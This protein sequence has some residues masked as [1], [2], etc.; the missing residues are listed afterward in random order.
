MIIE[1]P[2]T[3]T[4]LKSLFNQLIEQPIQTK[5][6][7]TQWLKKISDLESSVSEDLAWRYIRMT[8][9]T[10]NKEHEVA[11]LDFVQ[12]IQPELAPLED[13]L[14]RKVVA[15]PFAKEAEQDEAVR[16][17]FRSLRG[18]IEL[19]REE[20]I[21]LQAELSTLAQEYSSIQGAMSVNIDGQTYTMQQAS[22]FLLRTDRELREKVWKAM[23]E[24][25]M[26]DTQKLEDLFDAMVA[27]RQEVAQNAGFANF[28]DYMFKALGR[29]DYNAEDCKR[30]HDAIAGKVVPML[31]KLAQKRKQ[32]LAL[33]TLK[34][35]DLAVDPLGREPLK[36]FDGG[37]ELLNKSL[38]CLKS[39]DS[40]FSDCLQ[41]MQ[42]KSLLDLE[43][44]LG[45]APGGYNYPLAETNLPFIFMNASGNLRDV[46]TLVHEGGHAVHSFLMAPL[47]LNAFKNT[48]SE[49]AELASMSMELISMKGW[50][51]YF[52]NPE[53]LKRA[54]TEQL[55]GIIGTLPWIA[56]VDA[57][58]HW[59]Y[60]NPTH[61]R[62]DRKARWLELSATFGTGLTDFSGYEDALAYSWHKQ[63]HIYEVPFYYVE[64]GFAQLGA[65]GVWKNCMQTPEQG[66]QQYKNALKLGYTRSIPAIYETAG[67]KFDFSADYIEQLFSFVGEE[68][69]TLE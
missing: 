27:K 28:R 45:K 14:N 10:T 62:A 29:Y 31:K 47:A 50:N 9:D 25:R 49:V 51:A 55:E 1:K 7:F 61:T 12:N 60:E 65:I 59:I 54:Q 68:L 63:L 35:W 37:N 23:H 16:I 44:R 33:D 39:V 57:F 64:Y 43:S 41:T 48:P 4:N 18:A 58:Q 17:Y 26:Q 69:S 21:P 36:P 46:E 24:R 11:Y 30:F 8:C 2:L 66:L 53:D 32:Q 15:S 40:F 13:Q 3:A 38:Q 5:D 19:Y 42:Q 34:P 20:N 56:Q 6:E 52:E 22:N 67:V